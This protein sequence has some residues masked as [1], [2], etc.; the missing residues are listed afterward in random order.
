MRE[1]KVV[2]AMDSYKGCLSA[3][4]V[5]QTVSESLCDLHPGIQTRVVPMSDGG[6]GM[7]DCIGAVKDVEWIEPAVHD[8]LMRTIKARYAI[9]RHSHSTTAYMEMASASGLTL[10][11]PE[12][13]NPM[14]TTTYG[15][16]EMIWDAVQRGCTDIVMGIGGSATCDGGKGMMDFLL[17][18]LPLPVKI[19]VACDVNNPLYGPNGSAYVFAPQK[20]ASPEDVVRLDQRLRE[21]HEWAIKEGL[22]NEDHATQP[23]AGA[24]GGLGYALM[25]FLGAELTSGIQLMMQTVDL[26][27]HLD[28]ADLVIT[29]EGCSDRQTLMGKVPYGILKLAQERHIP[30]YLLSGAIEDREMLEKSGFALVKS[31]NEGDIRPLHELLLA[32]VA[33]ENIRKTIGKINA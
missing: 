2:I 10:L 21:W 28:D 17:P 5:C 27:S 6:E 13:R 24:A 9:S 3:R 14:V 19:T 26:P 15:V 12:E 16:G 7:V 31:I 18:H 20:G 29:G 32:S 30:V 25:A 11:Q 23:G 4:E 33:R 1:M 22:A 8:P